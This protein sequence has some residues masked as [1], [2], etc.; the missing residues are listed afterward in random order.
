MQLL[1]PEEAQLKS[2]DSRLNALF[3]RFFLPEK[4]CPSPQAGSDLPRRWTCPWSAGSTF[5]QSPPSPGHRVHATFSPRQLNCLEPP[6]EKEMNFLPSATSLQNCL[7]GSFNNTNSLLHSSTPERMTLL[8]VQF[9][10][11]PASPLLSLS[12][13]FDLIRPNLKWCVKVMIF[14]N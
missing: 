7:L 6:L 9:F 1:L 8:V 5:Q 13:N 10:P 12:P 14:C 3:I 4:K 2:S 11:S